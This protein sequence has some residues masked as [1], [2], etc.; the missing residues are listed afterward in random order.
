[1]F[2]ALS[3]CCV[4]AFAVFFHQFAER[5]NALLNGLFNKD[6]RRCQSN[7]NRAAVKRRRL[8]QYW[9]DIPLVGFSGKRCGLHFRR[10]LESG[11]CSSPRRNFAEERGLL[12]RPAADNQAWKHTAVKRLGRRVI[13]A[14]PVTSGHFPVSSHKF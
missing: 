13:Y 3:L 9:I 14:L 6:E 8:C 5:H 7:R 2:P 1:M 11:L 10:S 12:S 4:F